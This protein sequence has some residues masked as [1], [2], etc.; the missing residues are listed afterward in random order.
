M[1]RI[2]SLLEMAE[3]ARCTT[4]RMRWPTTG[5]SILVLGRDGSQKAQ[6]NASQR[7]SKIEEVVRSLLARGLIILAV[8][9]HVLMTTKLRTY[10]TLRL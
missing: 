5:S 10:G 8:S 7:T 3:M 1:T 6:P 9:Q 2:C 4:C